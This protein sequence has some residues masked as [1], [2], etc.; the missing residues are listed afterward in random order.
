MK[1]IPFHREHLK[2]I[3]A[4]EYE[5]DH[6]I[7]FL[8]DGFLDRI[9]QLPFS[10]TVFED[11]RVI[12][13]IGCLPLWPGVLEAWQ[14]PSVYVAEYLRP[15]CRTIRGLLDGAAERTE[16]WRIQT[17][18]PADELHDR[19][20]AFIGFEVEGTLKE[21]SRLKKDYRIWA[22]RYNYGR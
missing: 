4:R 8:T 3:E 9:E 22:R 2:L 1:V 17:F 7:P 11:G 10:Y 5:R 19:W 12:T 20:M 15:Y 18:S 14:I 13:C 6:L 21:Y 16:V